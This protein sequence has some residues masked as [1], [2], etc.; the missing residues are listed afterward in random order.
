MNTN[1]DEYSTKFEYKDNKDE[2]K[3]SDEFETTN[4][5]KYSDYLFEDDNEDND[6]HSLSNLTNP[7]QQNTGNLHTYIT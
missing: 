6:T 1:D 4:K 2:C 7:D 3:D 5:R